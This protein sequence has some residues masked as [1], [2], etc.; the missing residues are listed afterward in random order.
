[1][2][3]AC[4]R[5]LLRGYIVPRCTMFKHGVQNCEQL[6]HASG[7]GYLFVLTCSTQTLV[8]V[9]D[10]SIVSCSHQSPHVEGCPYW[11]P[12]SPDCALPPQCATVSVKRSNPC[13]GSYLSAV[14]CAQFRQLHQKGQTQHWSHSGHATQQ[15][16]L[17][18]PQRA[19]TQGVS[20]LSI[21]LGQ[22]LLK[23]TEVLLD[24][25]P[26]RGVAGHQAVL[27]SSEHSHDL[28]PPSKQG[29]QGP[30]LLVRQRARAGTY[31]LSK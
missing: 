24:F 22:V 2:S 17:L 28:P 21:Q 4:C 10:D 15:F 6:P 23:P 27:L 9:P 14:Q 30:R 25:L 19:I 7:K 16:L 12:S 31:S 26:H 20:Q 11:S 5:D 1:M 29:S 13:Q 3:R 8:E 18:S